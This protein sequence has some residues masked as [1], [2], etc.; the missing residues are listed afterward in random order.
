MVLFIEFQIIGLFFFIFSKFSISWIDMK[1][2][3]LPSII[4]MNIGLYSGSVQVYRKRL[5]FV[6]QSKISHFSFCNP[7]T[8]VLVIFC[9]S[10]SLIQKP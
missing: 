5:V 10:V 2:K 8:S 6:Q 9:K 7:T 4:V 1:V 3:G